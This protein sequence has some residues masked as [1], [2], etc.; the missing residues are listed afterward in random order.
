M[1]TAT[2]ERDV[3]VA[4]VEQTAVTGEVEITGGLVTAG[5]VTEAVVLGTE[6]EEPA[7]ESYS[8]SIEWSV[9]GTEGG[10]PQACVH[11]LAIWPGW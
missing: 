1:V 8:T 11:S 6:S 7:S 5:R 10:G 9:R 2:V 4:T 3:G